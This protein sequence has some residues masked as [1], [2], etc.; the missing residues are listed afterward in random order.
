R[1][2]WSQAA[3]AVNGVDAKNVRIVTHTEKLSVKE[4]FPDI[5]LCGICVYTRDPRLMRVSIAA[6]S[7][8]LAKG[9]C[10]ASCQLSEI[11]RCEQ[12][13]RRLIGM[14]TDNVPRRA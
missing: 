6:T 11:N 9:V 7:L 3:D 10:L 12:P 4:T 14:I 5:C 2:M 1:A 13:R 8:L